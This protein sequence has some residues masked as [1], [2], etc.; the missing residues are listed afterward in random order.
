MTGVAG[1]IGYHVARALLARG[2]A[3]VGVDNLNSYYD[4][5]LKRARLARLDGQAFRFA[6]LGIEDAGAL[7]AAIGEIDGVINLAAQ[8]SVTHALTEPD[9]YIASNLVG[10]HNI[11]RLAMERSAG[12][13]VYAST[14]SVYGDNPKRPFREAD[15]ADHPLS[16]YAATKKANE[17]IAHVFSHI[18]G[19]P[20]TGLRFF[21]VYGPWGRP[22]MSYFKFAQKIIAGEP[23][24]L[25]NQGRMTRDFTYIDDI[26]A[27]VLATYDRPATIDP[28]WAG[29]PSPATSGAGPYR[30]FNIGSNAPVTLAQYVDAFEAAIGKRAIRRYVPMHPGEAVDTH[31]D[32]SALAAWT[33]VA[34]QVSLVDGVARFVAWY[35]EHF[36]V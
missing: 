8:A 24:E 28:D 17:A 33:G 31:A 15:G 21:T 34:P 7:S 11:A 26:V 25:H 12:H 16:L 20:T 36:G 1:F 18:H 22:D 32:S 2:D 30:I 4:V 9:D 14:S 3:V 10:F 35:R 23:I 19:L 13:L 27:G 5:S 29:A 6:E